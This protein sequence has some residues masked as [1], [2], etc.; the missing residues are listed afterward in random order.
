MKKLV[1]KQ[2]T[3]VLLDTKVIATVTVDATYDKYFCLNIRFPDG[4]FRE[5][6]VS[7]NRLQPKVFKYRVE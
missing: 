1:N 6:W 2:S 4:S 7:Y 3:D 5:L